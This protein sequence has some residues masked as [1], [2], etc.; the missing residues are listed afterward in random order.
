MAVTVTRV[1]DEDFLDARTRAYLD[2]NE[3]LESA[4]K[5]NRGSPGAGPVGRVDDGD[6]DREPPR[7]TFDDARNQRIRDAA[8]REYC[9]RISSAWRGNRG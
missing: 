2:R 8:N 5:K 9:E 1:D 6:D 4:W 3:Y 7:M